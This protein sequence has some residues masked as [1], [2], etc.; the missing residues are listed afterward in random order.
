MK[1]N[2][3]RRKSWTAGSISYFQQA[4][5]DGRVIKPETR[6]SS[7]G[8]AREQAACCE[9][10]RAIQDAALGHHICGLGC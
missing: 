3:R 2:A 5:P 8:C 4:I 7:R 9:E 6:G 10:D 1:I